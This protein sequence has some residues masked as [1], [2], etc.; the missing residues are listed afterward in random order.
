[1]GTTP[2]PGTSCMLHCM[3]CLDV[4]GAVKGSFYLM[5]AVKDAAHEEVLVLR[6][7]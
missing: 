1:M 3:A 7:V 2:S 6:E 5:T 4:P